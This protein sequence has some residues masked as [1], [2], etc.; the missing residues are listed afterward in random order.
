MRE[1]SDVELNLAET[2]F[3]RDLG[4]L[5][6]HTI[7]GVVHQNIHGDALALQLVEEKLR[8]WHG[9]EIERD[10]LG[11]NPKL[12]LKLLG[13]LCEL[14][15]APGYENDVVM[16]FGKKLGQFISDAAGRAGDESGLVHGG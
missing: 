16:I 9:C 11:R 13:K 4:K 12:A 15:R 14:G 5:A 1:R 2:F 10:G 6:Q 7:A 8:S 3:P